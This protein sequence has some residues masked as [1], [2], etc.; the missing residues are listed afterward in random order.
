MFTE[1]GLSREKLEKEASNLLLTLKSQ[2]RRQ[3]ELCDNMLENSTA[4]NSSYKTLLTVFS[5]KGEF[6]PIVYA[7]L[8]ELY[9][10]SISNSIYCRIYGVS[11][12]FVDL[13]GIIEE[14]SSI[15]KENELKLVMLDGGQLQKIQSVE[16]KVKDSQTAKVINSIIDNFKEVLHIPNCDCEPKQ[17]PMSHGNSLVLTPISD[18]GL[19]VSQ[20]P[21]IMEALVGRCSL[22]TFN[23][24]V[25]QNII[26]ANG[27]FEIG[28]IDSIA[29]ATFIESSGENNN[30]NI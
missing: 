21:Q 18:N 6:P 22:A 17:Y 15:I 20:I 1:N 7:G 3:L 10:E 30:I 23:I 25:N 14:N 19:P 24:T 29:T 16:D 4:H 13:S 11:D 9:F 12:G 8:K 28:T 2:L 27:T 26:N 5:N